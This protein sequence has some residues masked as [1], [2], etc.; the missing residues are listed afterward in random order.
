[1]QVR[2]RIAPGTCTRTI[3]LKGRTRDVGTI[4]L[5]YERIDRGLG[6]LIHV[7]AR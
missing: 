6:A 2:N 7:S 4:E 1:V 5:A 3:D